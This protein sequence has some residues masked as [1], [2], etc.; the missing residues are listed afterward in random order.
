MHNT[1]RQGSTMHEQSKTRVSGPPGRR[2]VAPLLVVAAA[3]TFIAVAGML[4]GCG[5]S[6]KKTAAGERST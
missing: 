2:I 1:P 4:A 6:K 3:V 5:S